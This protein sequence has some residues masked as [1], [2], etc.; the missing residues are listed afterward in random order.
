MKPQGTGALR[1]SSCSPIP[2]L[3]DAALD[4]MRR[5]LVDVRD[6]GVPSQLVFDAP[7]RHRELLLRNERS[8]RDTPATIAL[9]R[10]SGP[11]VA[12]EKLST[13]RSGGPIL[14]QSACKLV[15]RAAP[16]AAQGTAGAVEFQLAPTTGLEPRPRRA[17]LKVGG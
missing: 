17:A 12:D 13:C 11:F 10:V 3:D 6:G 9:L 4:A 7:G 16:G 14:G 15:L 5:Y 8:A 2:R 1:W